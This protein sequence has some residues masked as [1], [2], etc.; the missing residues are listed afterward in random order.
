MKS[1][2]EQLAALKAKNAAN[3]PPEV[4]E[5]MKKAFGELR[6]SGILDKPLKVSDKAPAFALPNGTGEIIRS[7][8][9]LEKGPLV[10]HFY[11]GKW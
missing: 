3:T 10:I 6:N 9:L 2:Q 8:T 11:R 5:K 1:L 7:E 4:V